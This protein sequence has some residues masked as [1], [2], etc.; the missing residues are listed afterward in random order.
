MYKCPHSVHHQSWFQVLLLNRPPSGPVTHKPGHNIQRFFCFALFSKSTHRQTL[1]CFFQTHT[2]KHDSMLFFCPC[3]C[4]IFS[5]VFL[6]VSFLHRGQIMY[7]QMFRA[8][9]KPSGTLMW[10]RKIPMRNNDNKKRWPRHKTEAVTK[11]S[12]LVLVMESII[13]LDQRDAY[14]DGVCSV[15]R[16]SWLHCRAQHGLF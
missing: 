15:T 1:T 3:F 6:L 10:N 12:D 8:A 11:Q 2:E 4:F 14:T 7:I 5:F 13:I 9:D 16:T